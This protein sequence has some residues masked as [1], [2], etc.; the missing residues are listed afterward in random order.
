MRPL[1]AA[2]LLLLVLAAGCGTRARVPAADAGTAVAERLEERLA[3]LAAEPAAVQKDSIAGILE[4][5][6]T[7]TLMRDSAAVRMYDFYISSPVMGAEEMAVYLYDEW[8]SKGKASMHDKDLE[9]QARIFAAFNRN[10]LIGM[11]APQISLQGI[12]G[13]TCSIPDDCSGRLAV[14]YF[15]DEGCPV[16]SVES[17]LLGSFVQRYSGDSLEIAAIYTGQD[18]QAWEA[19][20][21]SRL[22]SSSGPVT[23]THLWDPGMTSSFPML[24]G[25]LST[26]KMFLLDKDGT[27]LGR[28]L[29]TRALEQLLG[30]LDPQISPQEM[31][32]L[33]DVLAA[34]IPDPR[35]NDI[36]AMADEFV[37]SLSDAPERVRRQMTAALLRDLMARE[38]FIFK[39]AADYMAEK[40]VINS[41]DPDMDPVLISQARLHRMLFAKA[42]LG[43]QAADFP[44]P[45]M[46]G[47][48]YG[49][50]PAYTVLYVYSSSCE[51]CAVESPAVRELEGQYPSV[52]FILIDCDT[53]D[54]GAYLADNYD[55][56]V[57]PALLLI[58]PDRRVYAK[59]L[60]ARA[61]GH[62]LKAIL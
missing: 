53:Y 33:V 6:G 18:E 61:L 34:R 35:C 30:S 25:V 19:Y 3:A 22:P 46:K 2:L 36:C 17:A 39:C 38:E 48:L 50:A 14:L 27:I 55:I 5:F 37:S 51:R 41:P 20:R 1:A 16:C 62:L 11:K 12:W 52:R 26:P 54:A 57:L 13:G 56:S 8:F 49:T 15:Y 47:T 45:D 60:D 43:G 40:Y 28:N 29:G 58:G 44:L 42:P 21:T 23:V 31:H 32:T 4:S 59:Y 9:Q 24:Y 7:D 10:S